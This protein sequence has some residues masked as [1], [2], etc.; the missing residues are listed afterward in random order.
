MGSVWGGG[1]GGGASRQ[2][3][4]PTDHRPPLCSAW[5]AD[6]VATD[7]T[8]FASLADNQAP[9]FLWI[10]CSDSRVPANQ[11]LG[12][13]PGSLFVQRNVGNL[14]VHRDM[15]CMACLEYAVDTLQVEHVIVCGH[16]GCGAVKAALDAP[17]SFG[18]NVGHWISDIRATRDRHAADLKPLPPAER[19]AAL[20]ELNVVHQVF[21][22]ATSPA[23]QAAWARGQRVAVHALIYSLTDGLLRELVDAVTCPG[24]L[25]AAADAAAA[26]VAAGA[27]SPPGER[28]A[29]VVC[30]RTA[31][32]TEFGTHRWFEEAGTQG[33]AGDGEAPSPSPQRAASP[34]PPAQRRRRR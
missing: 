32:G 11:I 13:A 12:L 33:V 29:G 26:S 15:N 30:P 34:P 18:G 24:D 22:V 31:L 21:N 27:R 10:G 23:I 7:P 17:A 5:A 9:R 20:C 8:F 19:W 1:G 2:T 16:R 28:A 6:R 4:T 25:D 3:S 14:A